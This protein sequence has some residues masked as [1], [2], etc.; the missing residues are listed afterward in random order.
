MSDQDLSLLLNAGTGQ[1][2]H[3][4]LAQSVSQLAG[5][6]HQLNS[7]LLDLSIALLSEYKNILAHNSVSS[8]K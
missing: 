2:C 7:N 4:L 6:A 1:N 3:D 8:I 5:L